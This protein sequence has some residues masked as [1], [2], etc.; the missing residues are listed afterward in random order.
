MIP[1]AADARLR[2]SYSGAMCMACVAQSTPMITIGLT[3]MRRHALKGWVSATVTSLRGHRGRTAP[4]SRPLVG[5]LAVKPRA[6]EFAAVE[7]EFAVSPVDAG[8]LIRA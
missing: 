5:S 4:T 8:A 1:L 2:G 7:S 3:V 6:V